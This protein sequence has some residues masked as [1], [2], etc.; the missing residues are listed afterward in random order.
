MRFHLGLDTYS[1][2]LHSDV[3]GEV[4][5]E[6][7]DVFGMLD[8]ARTLGL[9]GIHTADLRHFF[10]LSGRDIERFGS[11]LREGGMYVEVGAAGS[12][13]KKLKPAFELAYR[14]EAGVVRTFLGLGRTWQPSTYDRDR[15]A[16]VEE[17]KRSAGLCE[18]YGAVLAIENHQD[19]TSAELLEV[20]DAVDS[21]KV[22]V[23]L[24]T[25]NPLGVF[26][27]PFAA[28][29]ALAPRTLSVH[30]KDYRLYP[31][32]DGCALVGVALGE[33]DVPLRAILYGLRR[34]VPVGEIALNIE[35]A[36]EFIPMS[37]RRPGWRR[38][39]RPQAQ[40]LLETCN[41]A[42]REP[43][44][45]TRFLALSEEERLAHEREQVERSVAHARELL[46]QT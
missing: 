20:L 44:D 35:S 21:E 8:F 41:A 33:G 36:V 25:G 28:A 12:S 30:L 40:D 45:V 2:H 46:G 22:G 34:S 4:P 7:L 18:E 6:P 38:S 11:E 17:L 39:L 31:S 32:H 3:W 29:H 16:R 9:D 15:A 43:P 27:D 23:C 13:P 19:L 24:D 37:E 5:T 26:E 1:L 42:G 10:S 14:L